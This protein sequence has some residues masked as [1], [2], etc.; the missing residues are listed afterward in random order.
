[1]TWFLLAFLTATFE[2][3]KDVASKKTLPKTNEY[4]VAWAWVAFSAPFQAIVVFFFEGL[5]QRIEP[6]F[7]V[8][9]AASSVILTS[10]LSLYTRAIKD[11]DLSI[12]V[13]MI[14]FTPLFLLITSPLIVG[15]FPS[16]VGLVGVVL[17]V[18]GS[19]V[20]NISERGKGWAAPYKALLRERGPRIMLFVAFLWSINAN[21]DKV[22]IQSSSP[23]FWIMSANAVA[24]VALTP[25]ILWKT[26]QPRIIATNI[27]SLALIGLLGALVGLTQMTALT[28]TIVPYVISV[29]RLSV[30]MSVLYGHMLFREQGLQQRLTGV[31]I[32]IA[33]VLLITLF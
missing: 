4:I 8:A 33:G 20:L 6:T 3:L 23:F 24:A 30:I 19:Y 28:M 26:R 29:K 16:P 14:A 10:S 11:S 5:P 22:G 18:V 7:W 32:M 31:V 27:W 2:S 13:P 12:T 9:L 25:L 21:I 17:I 1:M 15:E